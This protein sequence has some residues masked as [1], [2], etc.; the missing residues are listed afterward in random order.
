[1]QSIQLTQCRK[2][3]LAIF[4]VNLVHI[5]Q[6]NCLDIIFADINVHCCMSSGR[7]I[8]HSINFLVFCS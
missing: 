4:R 3:S 7:C 1:M 2:C 5:M 6:E 8:I